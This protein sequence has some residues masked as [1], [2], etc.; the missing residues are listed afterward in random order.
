MK[1]LVILMASVL[2]V[3]S[4]TT[5]SDISAGPGAGEGGRGA[6]AAFAEEKQGGVPEVE[7]LIEQWQEALRE[8]DLERFMDFYWPDAAMFVQYADGTTETFFSL[9]AIREN[10]R[11]IFEEFDV[12]SFDLPE[13]VLHERPEP[14]FV[15]YELSYGG[16]DEFLF[17][18]EMEGRWKI[19]NQ[20]FLHHIPG[21]WVT[22]RFQAAADINGNGFIDGE[23]PEDEHRIL[24]EEILMPLLYEPGDV[25]NGAD[26]LFDGNRDGFIDE[27]EIERA[28]NLIFMRNLRI[29]AEFDP[30]HFIELYDL[31]GDGEFLPGEAELIMEFLF[32]GPALKDERPVESDLDR[33]L[34]LNEDGRLGADEIDEKTWV[35]LYSI[36]T[37]LFRDELLMDV[38]RDVENYLDQAADEN[39]DGMVDERE[40]RIFSRTVAW[41]QP[42]ES[43]AGWTLDA[44]KNRY[45]ELNEIMLAR[46]NYALNREVPIKR[47]QPPFGV[48]TAIDEILDLDGNG[49]VEQEEIDAF[50]ILFAA[51]E[52][53]EDAPGWAMELFDHNRNGRIEVFEREDTRGFFIFP[54]PADPDNMLDREGD[55]N[56]DGFLEPEEI[57]ITAGVTGRG[58]TF[59]FE[60][61]IERMRWPDMPEEGDLDEDIRRPRLGMMEDEPGDV[62]PVSEDRDFK[63]E[64]YKRL[65]TIQ[66]KKLAIVGLSM[67]TANVNR[68]TANGLMVF[69]ENAFVNIG[70]VRVVD[71]KNIEK[72]MEEYKFQSSALTDENTA[73]EIGKLSG[74]D[75]IVIGSINFV[76]KMYYLNIKLINVETGEIIGSS[77]AEAEDASKFLDMSNKAVYNLF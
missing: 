24:V 40:H 15:I 33:W 3:L 1:K 19:A 42:V 64:Y 10:Q 14:G 38:P 49:R 55:R 48:R 73:V 43:Q 11:R 46:Q 6:D 32:G 20:E 44:N 7:K 69:V 76:G 41:E 35:L 18:R 34:D 26:E 54:H 37:M 59:N 39:G 2:L 4:C 74:A 75:I 52:P 36:G 56:G 68:E 17:F 23:G 70:K 45:L 12:G 60:E 53:V 63:S 30:G 66:D 31:N 65:G 28:R 67:G 16:M 77:I 51:E 22:S 71:R 25:R 72:I 8:E 9:D 47:V 29:T 57:G 5:T 50:V 58:E 13:P 62:P 61:R 27:R 21:P